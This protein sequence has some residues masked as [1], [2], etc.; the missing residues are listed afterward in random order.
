MDEAYGSKA[1]DAMLGYV[2]AIEWRKYFHSDLVKMTE[3]RD[4]DT[5]LKVTRGLK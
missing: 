2:S 4:A 3:S 5:A 1:M